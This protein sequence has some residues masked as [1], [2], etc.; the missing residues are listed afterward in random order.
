M[1]LLGT[2]RFTLLKYLFKIPDDSELCLEDLVE[3]SEN[4]MIVINDETLDIEPTGTA[5]C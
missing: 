3:L 4:G 1:K 5:G 2:M